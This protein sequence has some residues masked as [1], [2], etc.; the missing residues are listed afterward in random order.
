M[1]GIGLL[2]G[3]FWYGWNLWKLGSLDTTAYMSQ[4]FS[5]YV[6]KIFQFQ[7]QQEGMNTWQTKILRGGLGPFTR[8]AS[9]GLSFWIGTILMVITIVRKKAGPLFLSATAIVIVYIG[10][11]L[12]PVRY[13]ISWLSARYPLTVLPV[14]LIGAIPLLK[15]RTSQIT[16]SLAILASA[17]LVLGLHNPYFKEPDHYGDMQK[18][19]QSN[20]HGTDKVLVV[21]SPYFFV[22]NSETTGVDS[23]DPRLSQLYHMRDLKTITE[24]LKKSG[25]THLLMPWAPG[26]FETDSFIRKLFITEGLLQPVGHTRSFYL[27]RFNYSA[28]PPGDIRQKELVRWPAEDK[29]QFLTY[30]NESGIAPPRIWTTTNAVHTFAVQ[31]GGTLAIASAPLWEKRAGIIDAGDCDS[32]Q[33]RVRIRTHNQP[34]AVHPIIAMFDENGE[35]IRLLHP[36]RFET[37]SG[38]T[39]FRYAT[40]YPHFL[41]ER[42]P[43]SPD[44]RSISIGLN[45]FRESGGLSIEGLEVYGYQY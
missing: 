17:I 28:V 35:R 40:V 2:I 15:S 11:H 25:F 37:E 1:V 20:V 18:I 39:T 12:M 14:L 42:I 33:V 5:E 43:L 9:F 30:S 45:F 19:V 31:T 34:F 27:Y 44:C 22:Y 6:G 36:V 16:V 23:I 38:W 10:F 29:L 24:D 4:Y 7:F 32:V 3:C 26:P 41:T 21:H 8:M 13:N